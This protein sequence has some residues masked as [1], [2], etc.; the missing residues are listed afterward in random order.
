MAQL[1]HATRAGNLIAAP[2]DEADRQAYNAAFEELGLNWQWDEDTFA[3]LPSH[4]RDGVRA[5]LQDAQSH[6]LRAYDADF[7]VDVIEA[8]KA[9]HH[10]AAINHNRSHDTPY[11]RWTGGSPAWTTT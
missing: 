5:Y 6:L 2:S 10:E 9:R 8:T 4:G 7:L 1:F 3:A 11:F